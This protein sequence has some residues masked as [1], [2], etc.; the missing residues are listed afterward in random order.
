MP[1]SDQFWLLYAAENLV[2]RDNVLIATSP[3]KSPDCLFGKYQWLMKHTPKWCHR[4][5]SITPRKSWLAQPGVLLIDDCDANCDAFRS[6]GGDAILLPRPWN[7][8][9]EL[10]GNVDDYLHEQ[11][12]LR[13]WANPSM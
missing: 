4:Q 3:T 6:G 12:D 10:S 9:K 8:L 5:Y 7:T 1:K 13:K 11:L 2:G